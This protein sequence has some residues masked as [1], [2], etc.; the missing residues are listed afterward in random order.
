MDWFCFRKIT[1]HV[2]ELLINSEKASNFSSYEENPERVLC[3]RF[4]VTRGHDPNLVRIV[5][6][7]CAILL[8]ILQ[9]EY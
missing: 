6:F 1:G 3:S 8:T 2:H 7:Y 9:D 4:P 5:I